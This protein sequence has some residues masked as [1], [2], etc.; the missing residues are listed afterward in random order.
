MLWAAV[1][2]AKDMTGAGSLGEESA[3]AVAVAMPDAASR[4]NKKLSFT[5]TSEWNGGVSP[6]GEPVRSLRRKFDAVCNQLDDSKSV[7]L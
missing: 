2:F 6:A 4:M 3:V 5:R 7:P 1:S